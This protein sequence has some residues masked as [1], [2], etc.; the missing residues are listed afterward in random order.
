MISTF[1][2]GEII[3]TESTWFIEKTRG[4]FSRTQSAKLTQYEVVHFL[5]HDLK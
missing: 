2:N 5:S 3:V 4:K 1:F